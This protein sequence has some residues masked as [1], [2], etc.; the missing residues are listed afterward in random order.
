MLINLT[1][2]FTSEGRERKESFSYEPDDFSYMGNLY[3][4]REKS[5]V[6]MAFTNTGEGKV[7]IRGSIKLVM[8][9]FCDRCLQPV[10]E[11]V[12]AHFEQEAF[13]PEAAEQMD[14]QDGQDFMHEYE[15]DA[16]AFLNGEILMNM[17]VKVLCKPDCRG[18]CKICG[19]NLN[20]GE[21]G[22][23]TFVPDPRMAAIKDI[24]NENKE[25]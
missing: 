12:E 20:E 21:C 2:V 15:L 17:P 5:P 8:E 19:H 3:K 23:D 16:E 14:E 22:C 24:F 9:M 25:V 1:D 10:E 6:E 4:I 7:L 11:T 18:I 13:S